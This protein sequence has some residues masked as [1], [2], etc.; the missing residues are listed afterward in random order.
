MLQRVAKNVPN[1]QPREAA[2]ELGLLSDI[3]S[4]WVVPGN[5]I[6]HKPEVRYHVLA[7]KWLS[8]E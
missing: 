7:L 8:H 5:M 3:F 4:Q 6:G 2:L 1:I